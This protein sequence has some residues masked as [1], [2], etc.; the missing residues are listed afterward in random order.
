MDRQE[1]RFFDAERR[2]VYQ[3]LLLCVLIFVSF[4]GCSVPREHAELMVGA[5][6]SLE[7]V[8]QE[9][10]ATY[11]EKDPTV[12]L[13]F[14]FAGSGILEQQIREGA[15]IDI[16][17]SAAVK[18]MDSLEE[19]GLI[20]KDSKVNLIQNELALIV[21]KNSMAKI[22][23]FENI[24]YSTVIALGNPNSVPVGQYALEVFENIGN[25]D[26]V[27]GKVTYGKDVSEVLAWVKAGN[28]D[29]GV[30]YITDTVKED[31]VEVVTIA[32]ESSHSPIIYPAAIIA[33][34]DL[35]KQAKDFLDFLGSVE[36]KEI[37]I[38]YGFRTFE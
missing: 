13:S 37:F 17:V 3:L 35:E 38:E 34:T 26:N 10:K 7:P 12:E 11:L 14:T 28:A 1:I 6:A 9:L 5:A 25:W 29:A 19:D 24:Q 21:P 31:G 18:Q 4:T 30:V 27:E 15:P 20:M 23:S 36:A 2:D 32:P 16:F 33:E 22:T 8:L